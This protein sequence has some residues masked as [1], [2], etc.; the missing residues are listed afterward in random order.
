MKKRLIF[1]SL[2]LLSSACGIT[3]P[4]FNPLPTPAAT[5]RWRLQDPVATPKPSPSSALIETPIDPQVVEQEAER[6]L[7][8]PEIFDQS[9]PELTLSDIAELPIE[10]AS[11]AAEIP[12]HLPKQA[13]TTFTSNQVELYEDTTIYPMTLETLSWAER[14]IQV[15]LFVLGGEVGL[16]LAKVL[17]QKHK[18]GVRVDL[19][20][21]PNLGFA[22]TTKTQVDK[23]IKYL[24]NEGL[25]FK[26]Y[27]LHH[28]P[29][30]SPLLKERG[31]IDHNKLIVV[32]GA[33]GLIGGM[34]YF[35]HAQHNRDV[36][37]RISGPLVGEMQQ[38]MALDWALPPKAS[39]TPRPSATPFKLLDTGTATARGRS[40]AR[41]LKVDAFER[42]VKQRLLTHIRDAR[43]SIF[44]PIFELSDHDVVQALITAH[45]RGV[46]VRVLMDPKIVADKYAAGLPVPSHMPNIVAM[47][48]FLDAKVPAR[49][50]KPWQS[51]QELHMKVAIFD[52]QRAIVG[53]TNFTTRAFTILRETS[54]ELEGGAVPAALADRFEQDWAEHSEAITA[55]TPGQKLTAATV[56]HIKKH[57]GWW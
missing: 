15:D 22:G 20:L 16:D 21:D 42:T 10:V 4:D 52:R 23:V 3:K 18:E 8:H 14:H 7:Q 28:L 9:L 39:P 47:S 25:T 55:L 48:D 27:P 5:P 51:G 13:S 17:V 19:M 32:D 53:S 49:W 29:S 36:M 6:L 41:I 38:M 45:R 35:D 26:T 24:K 33:W 43:T 34:N 50:F 40:Q 1:S 37:L 57:V 11:P 31:Q 56:Q 54:V 30:N 12:A 44:L 46:D 2:F